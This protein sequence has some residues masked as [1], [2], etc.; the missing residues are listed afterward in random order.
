MELAVI[1]IV[2]FL[3]DALIGD[4]KRLPH[5]VIYIGKSI[6]LLERI[7]R[8][9]AK[10]DKQLKLAG[11]IVVI[12]IV[13]GTY[14]L[15]LGVIAAAFRVHTYLGWFISVLIMSQT[16][17][18]NS[19][20]RHA[21][22]VTKPLLR[23]DLKA[24]RLALAMIVGRDTDSLDE[25]EISRGV[26]ETVSE[27]TV[28]GVTAPIFYGML[29]GP[30]LAMAYKAVNT[31]DSMIGYKNERYQHFGWAGAKLDDIANFIPARLT[32]LFYLV[33]APLVPGRIKGVWHAIMNDAAKHP[34]PNS[35]IPE[36]AVAGA[37]QIQLGGTNYYEGVP[38]HRARMG[39][40]ITSIEA[41]HIQQSLYIMVAV[42]CLFLLSSIVG[43]IALGSLL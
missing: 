32:G 24:A 19:L 13:I 11:T 42:S 34:S 43:A 31:L 16:I 23:G 9:W 18:L 21:L 2:A 33:I 25:H 22:D 28:D 20:Y 6:S 5:P 38:S 35:G 15:V 26:I 29:G 10:S 39:K 1:L 7:A 17:A 8:A 12:I 41:K 36:A 27:N 37:L 4:P 14:A 3:V 30:A 40:P